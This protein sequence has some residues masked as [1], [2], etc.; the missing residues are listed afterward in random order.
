[1]DESIL[2][3]P[4]TDALMYRYKNSLEGGGLLSLKYF[5]NSTSTQAFDMKVVGRIFDAGFIVDKKTWYYSH[6]QL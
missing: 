3:F 4:P 6:Q 1:M 2:G 5:E